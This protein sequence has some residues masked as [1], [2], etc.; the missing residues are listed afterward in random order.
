MHIVYNLLAYG[1]AVCQSLR[2]HLCHYLFPPTNPQAR[3][4]PA[5]AQWVQ[6]MTFVWL[7][8][9]VWVLASSSY[10]SAYEDF[11]DG[12]YYVRRQLLWV[13]LGLIEFN[14]I[15]RQPL[16]RLLQLSRW[17]L[18]L[19]WLALC[20]TLVAG[21]TING[22]TRWL[23][24]GPMLFQPSE[25]VKP[26]LILESASLFGHWE[27]ARGG[28]TVRL[29]LFAGIIATILLQPN[30]ST[31]ALC[32][33]LIWWVALAGGL[34]K[35][36]LAQVAIGGA[37]VGTTSVLFREYQ[38]HRVI[39]FLNPWEYSTK[40]GYQLVQSLLA[41]GSGGLQGAGWGMSHQKMFYLPIQY[42]DFIFAI[43][44][45]EVGFI[46]CTCVILFLFLYTIMGTQIV[47]R[48]RHPVHRLVAVG[49]ITVLIGQAT[50][51]MGVA[52]GLLPT[53]GLPFPFFS[54]GGNAILS[55]MFVA[56]ML[57]RVARENPDPLAKK[58]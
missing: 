5:S 37:C 44:A 18:L 25:M 45:E 43:L 26:L 32:G 23:A 1:R 57:V 54:Y 2:R 41:M 8:F 46:G 30:L 16:H 21:I 19:L 39:S 55:T 31:A 49:S 24:V 51:N 22:S 35:W 42:T 10:P 52:M 56:A 12:L 34:P 53:T 4:W 50:L 6:W 48:T 15:V 36:A 13:G 14:V 20:Y 17:G 29:G 27:R 40:E 11:G 7:G 38:R 33:T 58:R 28:R 3:F 9:G 47:S